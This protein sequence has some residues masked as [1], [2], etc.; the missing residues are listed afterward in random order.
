M[1][2]DS[3]QNISS[4]H[5]A[6]GLFKVFGSQKVAE[7]AIGTKIPVQVKRDNKNINFEVIIEKMPE[8]KN[9]QIKNSSNVQFLG[10]SL[11]DDTSGVKIVDIKPNSDAFVKGLKVNNYI[12]E[13]FDT[14]VASI[15][16]VKKINSNDLRAKPSQIP[17]KV[18]DGDKFY[19]LLI[20]NK[21][22]D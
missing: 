4:Y 3:V 19:N 16:D 11:I 6:L 15:E 12:V 22:E 10:M 13:I 17:V 8:I 9:A 21:L 7:T 2:Q 5:W 18:K 1:I 20:N 14:P